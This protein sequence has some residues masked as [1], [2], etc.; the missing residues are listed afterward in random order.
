MARKTRKEVNVEAGTVKIG[1]YDG[2]KEIG[3]V[4]GS[5]KEM[6]APMIQRLAMHGL[7]QKLGDTYTS[8]TN[9]DDAGTP[10]DG[11]TA[12][13]EIYAQL[14]GGAWSER[15]AGDGVGKSRI[16]VEAIAAIKFGGDLAKANAVWS[17]ATD[18]QKKALRSHP[19]IKGKVADI[20]KARAVAAAKD[21]PSL[22]D[23]LK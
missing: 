1:V 16:T 5:I 21:A 3:S 11:L 22:D 13:K 9:G 20:Q 8:E 4:L 18:E 2:E 17:K 6:P 14:K 23:L 15:K 19:T 10:A 12:M 7:A